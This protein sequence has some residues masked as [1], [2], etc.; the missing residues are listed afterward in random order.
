MGVGLAFVRRPDNRK[1]PRGGGPGAL[2]AVDDERAALAT[3]RLSSQP[4]CSL[5][6]R[7]ARQAAATPE[8]IALLAGRD[9]ITYA[10]LDALGRRLARRLD[11]V[12]AGRQA[13]VGVWADLG[14]AHVAALLACH[15]LG[16]PIVPVDPDRGTLRN[17]QVLLLADAGAVVC[18][19]DPGAV[20][21]GV[22]GRFPVVSLDDMPADGGDDVPDRS[23]PEA[24]ALIIFTSGS[25]GV[26][27]GV[28]KCQR[29]L[30]ASVLIR[31]DILG[32]GADDVC[33][34]AGSPSVS[35]AHL[36]AWTGLAAGTAQVLLPQSS[37]PEAILS[38]YVEAGVTCTSF[39]IGLAR[40]LAQHPRARELLA[41]LRT[42]TLFGDVVHW[43]DVEMVR[44][45]TA[46]GARILCSFGATEAS[47]SIGWFV[48][49]TPPGAAGRTPIGRCLPG[50]ALW[51]DTS[52]SGDGEDDVGE[53][54][55]TSPRLATGYWKDEPLTAAWFLPD[56]AGSGRRLFRTGDIVRRRADGI[57]EFLG[58]AD[59][60]I[61][62][63]GWRIELEEV[64]AVARKVPG[65][66]AACAVARRNAEGDAHALALYVGFAPGA[67]A[68]AT[69]VDA[70]LRDELPRQMWSVEVV[71]VARFP[72]TRSVKV[73][74]VKLAELDLQRLERQDAGPAPDDAWPDRLS[75]RI[76]TCLADELQLATLRRER[77]FSDH[78]G[79]SLRA[80]T[81]ALALDR[82]FG[83]AVD[84]EEL[85][86]DRSLDA[87]VASLAARVRHLGADILGQDREPA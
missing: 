27:K 62:L 34:F 78:G 20:P 15:R 12:L 10:G 8:R 64:E 30:A 48:P 4:Y 37:Q 42:L 69:A 68:D 61:K 50:A 19:G 14:P 74:R 54:V 86:G 22:A 67:A 9:A 55:V 72:M 6:E 85:L 38:R 40:V 71:V 82:L 25:T 24:P 36:A 53:L 51:L 23:T 70:R 31:V 47:W 29:S 2:L 45:A 18:A 41:G 57:Y 13:P 28:V 58:R 76:A 43:S 63:S 33:A 46:P 84:P 17:L 65:V 32:I 66:T 49:P 56:P 79:N 26:P 59:H 44:A 75:A 83:L 73:D 39:Y 81:C 21:D 52:E 11:A 35:G 87:M 16:L 1:I 5:A 80:L 77:S 60:Q 7:I 3:M